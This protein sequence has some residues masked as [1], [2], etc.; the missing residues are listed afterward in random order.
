MRTPQITSMV[1]NELLALE[2]N[3]NKATEQMEE[4]LLPNA[5]VSQMFVVTATNNLALMLNEALENLEEQMANSQPG[6]QQCENPGGKG[7][8]GMSSMKESSESMKKQLQ[9]MIDQM[10]NGKGQNM[11]KQMGQSLMQHE[12]MQQ[13]LRDLMNNG[14]VGSGT[15]QKLQQIDNMLE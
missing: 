7:K 1:N 6:D 8:S 15:K 13:M 11:S 10:K 14:S 5:R 3:L 2:L 9:K 4:A 12:M